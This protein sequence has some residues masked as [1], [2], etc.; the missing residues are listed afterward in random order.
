MALLYLHFLPALFVLRLQV[1]CE[2][3]GAMEQHSYNRFAVLSWLTYSGQDT[4]VNYC[5]VPYS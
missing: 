2:T 1:G 3:L 5:N 4:D